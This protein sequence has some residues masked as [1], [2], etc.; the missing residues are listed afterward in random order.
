MKQ[1]LTTILAG[2]TVMLSSCTNPFGDSSLVDFGSTAALDW[3]NKD[4]DFGNQQI[5]S[6]SV[7]TFII[8]NSGT[9]DATDCGS[10]TLSD[11][12]NFG[13]VSQ[14]CTTPTLTAGSQCEV[15]V[16]S[17]PQTAGEKTLVIDRQC[18]V[19]ANLISL[20]NQI[21]VTAVVPTAQW[22]PMSHSFGLIA[23]NQNTLTK[24]FVL[25]N[26]GTSTIGNCGLVS[27][28]NPTDFFI[29]NDTCGMN[30]LPQGGSCE[31]TIVGRPSSAGIK[32]TTL[33]RTCESSFN[34]STTLDQITVEGYE[35][36]LALYPATLDL[37]NI[38][39]TQINANYTYMVN[40]LPDNPVS[41]SAA[42]LTDSTHF[43]ITYDDCGTR[44]LT[45][46]DACYIGVEND[47]SL[48][49]GEY[50][51]T[52]TKSCTFPDTSVKTVTLPVRVN[53][54]QP[55]PDLMVINS[56]HG[57]GN[58]YVGGAGYTNDSCWSVEC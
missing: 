29:Q 56:S 58:T 10:V 52:L 55:I 38:Y 49:V 22:T 31:V 7:K 9:S 48:S 5:G 54:L 17:R 14:T 2:L 1:L 24:K 19:K 41:C 8:S 15:V 51:T 46:G 25:S 40:E 57:F 18:R 16:E 26:S 43:N 33:N 37:G 13:I 44:A 32:R 34:F 35:S 3:S 12:V 42:T 39:P 36:F 23:N 47:G 45:S 6:T 50:Q 27:V 28:S 4:F 30:N 11:N 53:V 21:K 20:S